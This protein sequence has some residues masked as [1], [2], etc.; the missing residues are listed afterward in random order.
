MPSGRPVWN[1]STRTWP[2]PGRRGPE[3]ELERHSLLFPV[4]TSFPSAGPSRANPRRAWTTRSISEPR[5]RSRRATRRGRTRGR[6][7]RAA[8]RSAPS[9]T[10]SGNSAAGTGRRLRPAAAC[11]ATGPGPPPRRRPAG[12]LAEADDRPLVVYDA[13]P[14]MGC[15]R[16]PI[17]RQAGPGRVCSQSRACSTYGAG[18]GLLELPLRDAGLEQ[19]IR[20]PAARSAGR[21]AATGRAARSA[22]GPATPANRHRSARTLWTQ[23][24][25]VPWNALPGR[26]FALVP[27]RD[28]EEHNAARGKKHKWHRKILITRTKSSRRSRRLR[29][30]SPATG[31]SGSTRAS[32]S[33]V[34]GAEHRTLG[35]VR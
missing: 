19:I 33:V 16:H 3:L 23:P 22:P 15:P 17:H 27:P 26:R 5:G 25:R 12:R 32:S 35:E 13:G 6:A 4:T 20:S 1:A 9:W 29:P 7:R 21:S 10:F 14:G 2:G 11:A 28:L 24:S 18:L 34:R 31:K 8:K 30:G